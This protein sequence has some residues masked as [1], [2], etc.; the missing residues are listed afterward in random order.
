MTRVLFHLLSPEVEWMIC[1]LLFYETRERDTRTALRVVLNTWRNDLRPLPH[2]P[3]ISPH[4]DQ[5][6]NSQCPVMLPSIICNLNAIGEFELSL[7]KSL[8]WMKWFM[9]FKNRLFYKKK[10]QKDTQNLLFPLLLVVFYYLFSYCTK[11]CI[12]EYIIIMLL[13]D[14]ILTRENRFSLFIEKSIRWAVTASVWLPQC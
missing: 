5:T 3:P 7:S 10:S 14:T 9:C 6:P 12:F 2:L 13:K 4:Y 8:I 11:K 1:W